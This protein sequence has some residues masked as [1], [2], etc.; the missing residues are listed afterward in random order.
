VDALVLVASGAGL[1][2]GFGKPT[3]HDG[4]QRNQHV[5][6]GLQLGGGIVLGLR[7]PCFAGYAFTL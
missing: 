1:Y 6:H 3:S 7:Q 4:K 5:I 2:A